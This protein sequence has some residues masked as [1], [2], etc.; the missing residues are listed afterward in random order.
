MD[1]Q[2]GLTR[3]Q[4]D[5]C[6]V[7]VGCVRCVKGAGAVDFIGVGADHRAIKMRLALQVKDSLHRRR[8][9]RGEHARS[10][11]GWRPRTEDIYKCDLDEKLAAIDVADD[12][13]QKCLAIEQA[14]LD[15]STKCQVNPVDEDS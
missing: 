2:N 12:L 9:R 11:R 13:E 3:R 10:M 8:R 5:Y 4:L 15:A 7:D 14:L 6:L 1:L